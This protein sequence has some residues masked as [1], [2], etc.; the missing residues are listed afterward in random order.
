MT[1]REKLLKMLD[2]CAISSTVAEAMLKKYVDGPLGEAMKGRMNDKIDD[3]PPVLFTVC[4][5]GLRKCALEWIDENAPL[6]WA[7]PMFVD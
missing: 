7:R 4:W 6:H 3:Y 1:V 2:D 5:L